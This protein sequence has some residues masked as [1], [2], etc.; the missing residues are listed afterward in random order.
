MI[1]G[2]V[3]VRGA[4]LPACRRR[5]VS[6]A[7]KEARNGN[8][9]NPP[10]WRCKVNGEFGAAD[11][12]HGG[13]Y[14]MLWV[15]VCE[16]ASEAALQHLHRAT[17]DLLRLAVDCGQRGAEHLAKGDVVEPDDGQVAGYGEPGTLGGSQRAESHLVG[18]G[19]DSRRSVRGR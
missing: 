8:P 12:E 5:L 6:A 19:E 11:D 4:S 13:Q 15:R 14:F 17:A 7:G 9:C 3:A 16:I 1:G 10:W 18:G 2:I